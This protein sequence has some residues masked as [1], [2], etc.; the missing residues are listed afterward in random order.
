[1]SVITIDVNQVSSVYA[2]EMSK[3]RK[4]SARAATRAAHRLR[5]HLRAV[6]DEIGITDMGTYK[7]GF[8]VDGTSVVNDAPHAGI[9]ELGARPH[10]VSREGI[11]AIARWVRRKLRKMTISKRTNRLTRVKYGADEALRIAFAIARKISVEGQEPRYVMRDALEVARD[12]YG[13]ELALAMSG[14]AGG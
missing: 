7:A 1:M 4:M 9:V 8:R 11:E 3:V 13:Q 6:T 14:A 12:L 10:N 2:K 5:A